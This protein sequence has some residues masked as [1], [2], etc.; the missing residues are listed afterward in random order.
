M[1]SAPKSWDK[2]K[3]EDV[4]VS[5]NY[6]VFLANRFPKLISLPTSAIF[7]SGTSGITAIL[8]YRSVNPI[9]IR[10]DGATWWWRWSFKG[11][12]QIMNKVKNILKP[13]WS[14]KVCISVTVTYK[15]QIIKYRLLFSLETKWQQVSSN[16]R[17]NNVIIQSNRTVL[18]R[19]SILK[20]MDALK[21]LCN[22]V[23][24]QQRT[25]W[26]YWT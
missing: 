25:A 14:Q 10:A 4:V 2:I 13:L 11:S 16:N 5:T 7:V 9:D 3:V 15:N 8:K 18:W 20:H 24:L 19:K 17:R 12:N 26:L 6:V 1:Q 21:L 23:P 22:A